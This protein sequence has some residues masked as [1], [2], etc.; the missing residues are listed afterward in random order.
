L[1]DPELQQ[2]ALAY[3]KDACDSFQDYK[4]QCQEYVDQYGPLIFS[5]GA[6]YLQPDPV[7]TRL[8]YCKGAPAF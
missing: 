1:Q 6:A 4:A 5:M 2:Q 3:A 7:C 8:G